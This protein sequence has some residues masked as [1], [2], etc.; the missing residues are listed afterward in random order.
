MQ[1]NW[2]VKV[3]FDTGK[4]M[5]GAEGDAAIKAVAAALA[6]TASAKVAITGFT[7]KTGNAEANT[8]L[9]KDRAVGVRDA[10]K[11][12]GV[13]EDRISMQPP[14]FVEAGKD[15]KDNEARRVDINLA[16]K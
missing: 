15:G 13:A 2:P 12:A 7:D 14:V 4:A 1:V 9:A 3:Y 6:A 8:K 5:T 10:L 11:A 16:A